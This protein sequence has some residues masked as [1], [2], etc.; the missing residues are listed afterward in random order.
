M[1]KSKP[2]SVLLHL[3][4]NSSQFNYKFV[5]D[6]LIQLNPFC[7]VIKTSDVSLLFLINQKKIVF[8]YQQAQLMIDTLLIPLK[9]ALTF[10]QLADKNVLLQKGFEFEKLINALIEIKALVFTENVSKQSYIIF[11]D[12]FDGQALQKSMLVMNKNLV[13][14]ICNLGEVQ[15]CN[16]NNSK[17]CI[18]IT[19]TSERPKLRQLNAYFKRIKMAWLWI[20]FDC[21][22]V[23][24]GPALNVNNSACIE[25][26]FFREKSRSADVDFLI[27]LEKEENQIVINPVSMFLSEQLLYDYVAIQLCHFKGLEYFKNRLLSLNFK[28]VKVA[29]NAFM[30]S[31]L[32]KICF[33]NE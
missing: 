8:H 24:I 18:V 4:C 21:S 16:L 15:E 27:E 17:I 31:P 6:K 1:F 26:Y 29:D 28:D 30:Q 13:V 2:I 25:C 33:P 23:N 32:C 12:L 3:D 7:E 10:A 14:N 9:T 11:S 19:R 20:E 22:S 5:S